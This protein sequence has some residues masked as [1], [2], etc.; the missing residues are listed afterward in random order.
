MKVKVLNMSNNSLPKYQTIGSSGMDLMAYL[1]SYLVLQP[2]ERK[3]IPTGICIELPI[4]YEAQ[5]RP[6][7]G[8]SIKHGII[9][10]NGTIDSDYRGEIF[11]LLIN[12]SEQNFIIYSGDRIAQM[13]IVRY[14]IVSL[15][16]AK[17]ISKT[18]R[19]LRGLGSTG[20]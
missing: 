20:I 1:K 14:E 2:M 12:L 3:I 8:L 19:D 11:V 10:I 13:I 7:S 6:R 15:I 9:C 16:D 17:K 5:I 18:Q 4:G